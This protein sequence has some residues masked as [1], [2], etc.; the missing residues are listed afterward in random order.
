MRKQNKQGLGNIRSKKHIEANGE[1]THEPE[2]GGNL[3]NLAGNRE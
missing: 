2:H 3:D 1:T